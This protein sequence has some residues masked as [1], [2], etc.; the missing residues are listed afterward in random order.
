MKAKI[1]IISLR[2]NPAFVQHA[3]AFAKLIREAGH[4]PEFLLDD[5]YKCFP[6]FLTVAPVFGIE[7]IQSLGGWTHAIFMNSAAENEKIGKTLK[8]RGTKLIYILHEPWQ[9]TWNFIKSEGAWQSIKTMTAHR[10]ATPV[11]EICDRV[12]LASQHGLEIYRRHDAK[13]NPDCIYFPLIYDD[14][15]PEDKQSLLG[16]KKYL[17]FVGALCRSH[18]FDHY[19]SFMRYVFRNNLDLQFLIASRNPLPDLVRRDPILGPKLNQIEIRCGRPLSNEEMDRC[20]A[21]SFCVWM[22]YRR[23]TQSGVLPKALMFGAPVIASSVGSIPEYITERVNGRFSS[24]TDHLR[25][26]NSI[27][28]MW[29]SRSSYFERCRQTFLKE[30]FFRSNLALFKQLL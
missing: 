20:Y 15:A 16:R 21:E 28:E 22:L 25:T 8:S 23:S 4:E 12:L 3:I 2:F 24:A 9:I 11:L 5:R 1:G 17:G 27:Q 6:E 19:L 13:Y 26:W 10:L 18:G 7:C 30:F 14:T 29:N